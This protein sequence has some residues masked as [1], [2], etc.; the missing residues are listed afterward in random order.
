[1]L[2]VHNLNVDEFMSIWKLGFVNF[3]CC[4]CCL[5]FLGCISFNKS[6][7]A[8]G[9]Q[10]RVT[11]ASLKSDSNDASAARTLHNGSHLQPPVHGMYLRMTFPLY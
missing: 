3:Q 9:G 7:N 8:Q 6:N 10:S 11:S 5:F 1:M 2:P 4:D